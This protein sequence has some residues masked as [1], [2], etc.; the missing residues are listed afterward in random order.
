MSR[1]THNNSKT[2]KQFRKRKFQ[3]FKPCEH[4]RDSLHQIKIKKPCGS[5][6]AWNHSLTLTSCRS[7]RTLLYVE[8]TFSLISFPSDL[9]GVLCCPQLSNKMSFGNQIW[10]PLCLPHSM[11][12][13]LVSF[14]IES[15]VWTPQSYY[16][17]CS[18]GS[19][20][21]EK[22]LFPRRID[23]SV[24]QTTRLYEPFLWKAT[25]ANSCL[26]SMSLGC[27]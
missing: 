1:R 13:L 7:C 15:N 23:F 14:R 24:M 27:S 17:L 22:L 20:H 2:D 25:S 10:C 26:E 3:Q 4:T 12:I 19:W 8:R 11:F 21:L 18:S 9:S 6:C 5:W 16:F